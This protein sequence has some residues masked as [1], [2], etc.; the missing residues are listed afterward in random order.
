M[1][2]PSEGIYRKFHMSKNILYYDAAAFSD[3]ISI[4]QA[5]TWVDPHAHFPGTPSLSHYDT[6][7]GTKY[8]RLDTYLLVCICP[9]PNDSM[10]HSNFWCD[11]FV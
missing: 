5:I 1:G 6:E 11:V 4:Q 2:T 10:R 3:V 9:W 7:Q 8:T